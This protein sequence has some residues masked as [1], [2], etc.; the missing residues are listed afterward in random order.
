MNVEVKVEGGVARI[1][2][3]R[4]EKGNALT[5]A[6]LDEIVFSFEKL[7]ENPN[8]R[9]AVLAGHGKAFYGGADVTELRELNEKTAGAFVERIHLMGAGRAA[10]LVLT[11]EPIDAGRAY[12]WGLVEEVSPHPDQSIEVLLKNSCRPTA[13]P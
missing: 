10:W 9:V 5:S 4:P 11:G 8:L 13:T 7:S 2:L 6:F 1:F 12:Q 3:N